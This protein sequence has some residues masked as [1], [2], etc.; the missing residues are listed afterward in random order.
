MIDFRRERN[1]RKCSGPEHCS[2]QAH[3]IAAQILP[4]G[5][6]LLPGA[7]ELVALRSSTLFFSALIGKAGPDFSALANFF[8][9][10]YREC[11][12]L[13]RGFANLRRLPCHR[14]PPSIAAKESPRVSVVSSFYFA[15]GVLGSAFEPESHNHGVAVLVNRYVFG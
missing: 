13:L 7:V 12:R 1:H 3:V 15:V 5:F 2:K 6:S 4:D 11:P 10:T 14:L 9:N 8:I